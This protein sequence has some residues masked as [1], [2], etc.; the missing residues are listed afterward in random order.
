[1][2]RH[3]H[4][5]FAVSIGRFRQDGEHGLNDRK[6]P[7]GLIDTEPVAASCYCRARADISEL[8]YILRSN[9]DSV[10]ACVPQTNSLPN[11][12]IMRVRGFQQSQ[13]NAGVGKYFH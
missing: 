8:G 7:V 10:A 5:P 2:G 11:R 4:S 12:D 9:Y 13:E 1:M 3:E 6:P